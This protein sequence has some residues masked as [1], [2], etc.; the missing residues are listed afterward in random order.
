MIGSRD[1]KIQ[2]QERKSEEKKIDREH[3]LA[4]GCD[5]IQRHR[6]SSNNHA[7]LTGADLI[8]ECRLVAGGG[9]QQ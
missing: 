4:L 6:R 7:A 1:Q 2:S 8:G 5:Q 3:V 9:R